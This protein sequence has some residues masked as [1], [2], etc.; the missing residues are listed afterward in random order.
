MKLIF[1]SHFVLQL[2]A[3]GN[4]LDNDEM[5]VS[6]IQTEMSGQGGESWRIMTYSHFSFI[7]SII[8]RQN[9]SELSAS[10]AF[11]DLVAQ[12]LVFVHFLPV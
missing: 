10:L 11:L 6:L 3:G 8:F 1:H 9:L 12:I 7:F 2:T 5:Y 4:R